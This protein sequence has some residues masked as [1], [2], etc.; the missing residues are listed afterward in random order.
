MFHISDLKKFNRCPRIFLLDRILEPAPFRRMVRLD[1]EVTA[2]AAEYLGASD[3][4]VGERGDDPAKSLRALTEHE[5]VLKARFEYG[6]LR[7][8]VPFLHRTADGYDLYFL[9]VGLFPRADDMQFYCDTVWVLEHLGIPLKEIRIIHLNASY[10]R[11]DELD[12]SRLFVTSSHFYNSKNHPSSSVREAIEA[13]RKDLSR[14]IARMEE[15]VDEPLPEPVRTSRCAG[16][17]KCRHYERCF[18]E[19]TDMPCN[20][21]LTLTGTSERYA[22]HREGI[23]YLRD[24]DPVR[25]EGTPM[26]Y[27]QIMADRCGGLYCDRNA[28]SAWFGDVTFPVSFIDFEWECFAIPPYR[29]MKPYDVLV[30]EYSLHILDEDGT[31]DH[32][33]FLSVHDDR[34]R[35]V[36]EMLKDIPE[37]GTIFAYNAEG[38]EQIR[39]RE[40]AGLFPEYAD[41]L[42]AVNARMKDLQAPFVCGYVYDTRMRGVWTLKRIMS[43]MDEPGYSELDIQQGMDAVFQ[44][45]LLD[46]EDQN[47]DREQIIDELKAYCGMD[48]YATL[49]VFNW[50]RRLCAEP[51]ND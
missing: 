41:G 24:A 46:R 15:A 20:S 26:Q 12:L 42:N 36:E 50:L 30:F 29:G 5:W 31:V 37:T 21:I 4:F 10:E 47:A 40:L 35:F 7:V 39:I 45:R 16:R 13:N 18:A 2:L 23:Q 9:F 33:V 51:E 28:L 11:G 3:C 6:G 14:Q 34:R 8:K 43:I 1:D 27:A 48:S 25:I 22:M 17:Q 19:E 44:W 38:A 49:V 32:K